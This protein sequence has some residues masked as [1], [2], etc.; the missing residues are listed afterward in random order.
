MKHNNTVSRRNFLLST[1][2]GALSVVLGWPRLA[3][4]SQPVPHQVHLH[5]IDGAV[6]DS[7]KAMM[8]AVTDFNWL[9]RG[10]T[11]F[12]K[13]ASNS[14]LAPPAVTSP[15]VLEGVVQ[16]LLEQG[17]GTVFVGDMSGAYYVRHLPSRTDGSTRESMRINGLLAAA[18]NAGAI[19]H[20]FEEVPF[21]EAYIEG[22]PQIDHH[23]GNDLFVA[24]VLDRVD[25]VINLPRLGKHVLAGA[26]LGL[27]NAVGWISDYS[28]MVL[29]RDAETFHEKIAEINAIPQ[30]Q[31][32]MR[33][34]MTLIDKALTTKGPDNGYPLE[35]EQPLLLAAVDVV[36]HDQIAL[37]VLLWARELTP[38]VEISADPYLTHAD[39][40]NKGFVQQVWQQQAETLPTFEALD[41]IN[42]STYINLAYAILHGGRPDQIELLTGTKPLPSSLIDMLAGNPDLNIGFG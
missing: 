15:A 16:T 39:R 11:V 20:C 30:L 1:C 17:A 25:H 7:V 2:A 9:K 33:L 32:K 13:V 22:V 28:R 40:Y 5:A 36:D 4:A 34:T 12:V 31:D 29:H 6:T 19:V 41:D 27:K 35:L 38:A 18:V 3:N 23:W 37:M 42:A 14:Y 26:T 21:K 8:R 24:E 10:D